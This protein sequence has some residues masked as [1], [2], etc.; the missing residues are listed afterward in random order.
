MRHERVTSKGGKPGPTLRHWRRID[1]GDGLAFLVGEVSG[2]PLLGDGWMISS[3]L[4]AYDPANGWARTESRRYQLADPYPSDL[5]LPDA[6]VGVLVSRVF[7]GVGVI[8]LADL[9]RALAAA[10][11][12]ARKLAEPI[13]VE[14]RH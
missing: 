4:V 8:E 7:D 10:E 12:I 5:A 13:S 3:P 2:H 11:A 9:P 6:A 14:S 1:V